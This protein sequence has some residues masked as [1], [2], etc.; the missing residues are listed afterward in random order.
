MNVT[1]KEVASEIRKKRR[2]LDITQEE[3]AKMIHTGQS[4]VAQM[5][6]G[7]KVPSIEVAKKIAKEL[8]I[9]FNRIKNAIILKKAEPFSAPAGSTI[10]IKTHTRIIIPKK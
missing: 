9:D 4:F 2:L 7:E 10:Q 6:K 3:F 8:D 1:W 5:E